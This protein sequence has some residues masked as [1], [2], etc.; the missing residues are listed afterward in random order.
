MVKVYNENYPVWNQ[1]GYSMV[2]IN[3]L[4]SKIIISY[5]EDNTVNYPATAKADITGLL[6]KRS[7]SSPD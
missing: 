3:R 7:P 1:M 4:W 5:N 6:H 2:V